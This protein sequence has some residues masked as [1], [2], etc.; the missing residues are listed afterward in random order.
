MAKRTSAPEPTPVRFAPGTIV[1]VVDGGPFDGELAEFQGLHPKN[2]WSR[3]IVTDRS[4]PGRSDP[5]RSAVLVRQVVAAA[6]G[7]PEG[8]SEGP[9]QS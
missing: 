7:C 6:T 4:V 3:V 5:V 1:R 9:Q 8:A 2:G